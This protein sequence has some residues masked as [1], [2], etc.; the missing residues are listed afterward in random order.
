MSRSPLAEIE[1]LTDATI[2]PQAARDLS[3]ASP[4]TLSAS[5]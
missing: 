2:R 3:G 4:V 1:G 5:G